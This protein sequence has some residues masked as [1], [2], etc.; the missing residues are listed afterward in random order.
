MLSPAADDYSNLLKVI[1]QYWGFEELRPLQ[2][3]AMRAVLERRDSLVVMPTGGGKSLCFQAPALLRPNETTVVVSPLIALMKDQ[4]DSLRAIGVSARNIDSTLNDAQR[5]ATFEELRTGKVRLLFVSPE[6]LVLNT[7]QD[8]LHNLGVRTFAIDEAHCISH[9]GHDF[10]PE[11]RQM[12]SVRERF[13]NAAFH[14]Y[15]ATATQRVRDDIVAQLGLRQPEVMVGNFDR[16]NLIYRV[17]SRQKLNDQVLEILA[18]HPKEAGIIYCIR[19]KDVDELTSFLQSKGVQALPYHAG[20]A[21]E[22]RKATQDAF[23]GEKCDL[24]VATVAFGMGIDRSNVRFVLHT[25]IPKSIEHYQQESGRAGRD[26]LE[27][28]CILLNSGRDFMLWKKIVQKS[29]EENPV[30]AEFLPMVMKH[31]EEINSYCKG[32]SCR[33]RSLVEHFGQKYEGENCQAC[34]LCMGEVEFEVDSQVIAQK[35]LSCVKRVNE[36]F[37]VGHVVSVLRGEKNERVRKFKHEELSTHGLLKDF[38]DVQIRDWTYQLVNQGILEQ[39]DDEYP[40]L[41]LLDE[42]WEVMRNQRQVRLQRYIEPKQNKQSR[43]EEDS[44]EGVNRELFDQLRDWRR[45]RAEMHNLAPDH[46]LSDASLR[47]IARRRPSTIERLKVVYGIGDVKLKVFGDELVNKI[48][49]YC[50][51]AGIAMDVRVTRTPS[52]PKSSPTGEAAFPLFRKGASIAE[53]AEKM[54]RAPSTVVAYLCD[55]INTCRP[56]SILPWVDDETRRRVEEAAQK[57]G[58][59]FL[60]P[61]FVELNEKIPYESIRIV[62]TFMETQEPTQS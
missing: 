44:W 31:L 21:N 33:H 27:A 50:Q 3:P 13:P 34:D 7:F 17:V 57:V 35:I 29:A 25:G 61:I 4:V 48:V 20:M 19:R 12:R 10:R 58:T 51:T 9:W 16:P 23:R 36:R 39:T 53:V 22:D 14:A 55:F 32:S 5:R 59:G 30:E 46:I 49:A 45:A 37:G 28:E 41:K 18:R 26:G 54:G 38:K 43:I 42:S 6:R 40:I 1:E 56:E 8:F 15:T 62:V 52:K 24:V 60:K 47:E 11:Y 2:E